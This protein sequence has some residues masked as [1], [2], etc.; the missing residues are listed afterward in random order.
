VVLTNFLANCNWTRPSTASLLTGLLPMVH[1]VE[2]DT[3]R[4][5]DDFVTLAEMLGDAGVVT[6]AVV[7]NGNAGSAFGLSR[8]FDFYADTV[9][10][11]RG[12]P[13]ADQVV[14]LAIPF[15]REHKDKRF[16]LLL[17][18]VDLHDPYH[19]P[20]E[21]DQMFVTDPS[22]A[23][24]RLIRS[25]HWEVGRYTKAEIGRMK[26]TYDGALRYTDTALGRF[27]SALADLGLWQRSTIM[28]T[29]DHGEAFGEHGVFLH[30]HHFYDEL[31]RVPFL[32]KAPRMSV[33]GSYNP[34]VFQTI[35]LLPTVTGLFGVKPPR[36]VPGIDIVNT[37]SN[38]SAQDPNR[39]VVADFNNFGIHRRMARTYNQKIILQEPADEREFM[40]TVGRRSLLPS[41]TFDQEQVIAYDMA[42]DP[43]ERRDLYSPA[44]LKRPAWKKLYR[45]LKNH[46]ERATHRVRPLVHKLDPETSADLKALGYIQ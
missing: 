2:A 14:E 34:H 37:L 8:G 21:F 46:P 33:R 26:D 7:G 22:H 6:G 36:P 19:A 5:A 16:F 24:A 45:L 41:V 13:S 25:P 27:F 11:W 15:V 39:V 32:V 20:G 17:F 28:V 44:L 43:F 38:S 23:R 29:A 9:K 31:V 42:R 18:F 1:G 12:L 40:A 4:L 10:H 35:D 30:S 3:D